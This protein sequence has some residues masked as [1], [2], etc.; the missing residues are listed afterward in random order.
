MPYLANITS[1]MGSAERISRNIGV[2]AGKIDLTSYNTTL[3]EITGITKYFKTGGVAGFTQGIVAVVCD[4]VS[5]NGYA[6]QWDYGTGAFKAYVSSGVAIP[7]DSNVGAGATLLFESGGGA[8]VIHATSAVGT[9]TVANTVQVEAAND[10][11][12]GNIGFV[13]I[14]F[15]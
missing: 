12:V 7:V 9:I 2:Y 1:P 10:D 4:P 14:G 15:I 3:I 11:D 6:V 8:G 13:A 5:E